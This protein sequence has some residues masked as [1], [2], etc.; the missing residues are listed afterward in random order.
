VE[1]EQESDDTDGSFELGLNIYQ[2]I[3]E[4]KREVHRIDKS[5]K[6]Q[7]GFAFMKHDDVT[8][9]L[10]GLFVKYGIDREVTVLKTTRFE[11]ILEMEVLVA[12]V[13]VDDPTDRKKVVVYT[14]GVNVMK[15]DGGEN[16]DGLASGKALSYAV[17][18]AE[19]KNFCL[20]GDTTADN[21]RSGSFASAP[22]VPP[23]SSEEYVKLKQLYE[24]CS[25]KDELTAIRGMLSPLVQQKKLTDEQVKELSKLDADAKVR[26]K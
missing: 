3:R 18:M 10:S 19:L 6:H 23:P 11:N 25:T 20:V 4:V 24:S 13:N 17:K 9:A 15:R 7:Q 22:D 14:E 16:R 12:W 21:E 5:G 26:S 2:R 1:S 8:A